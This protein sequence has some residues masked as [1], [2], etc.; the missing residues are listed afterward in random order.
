[1]AST[2][3]SPA[4]LYHIPYSLLEGDWPVLDRANVSPLVFKKIQSDANGFSIS[5]HIEHLSLGKF[6]ISTDLVA[7]IKNLSLGTFLIST[8]L[9]E[10]HPVQ[11]ETS[12]KHVQKLCND[13]M[14][15]GVSRIENP[16]VII[17]L[18]EGWLD[19]KKKCPGHILISSSCPHLSQLSLIPGGPIGQ[20]IRGSHRTAAVKLFS[21]REENVG[22]NYWAYNVLV[23]GE[24]WTFLFSFFVA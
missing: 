14:N 1:M 13:F 3:F 2:S 9:L 6:L 16:G 22:Q 8:D 10:P 19:M 7:H 11:R 23:P 5:T 18:G 12:L 15:Q 21:S 17:G 4:S 24:L 20:I